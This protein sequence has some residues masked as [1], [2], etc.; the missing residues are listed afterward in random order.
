MT[1]VEWTGNDDI[2]EALDVSTGVCTYCGGAA[3]VPEDVAAVYE[4]KAKGVT[5]PLIVCEACQ[6]A[7]MAEMDERLR[8]VR[9]EVDE[10]MRRMLEDPDDEA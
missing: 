4:D 9:G 5:V 6:P 8:K 3:R 2:R 7:F 1:K 10:L